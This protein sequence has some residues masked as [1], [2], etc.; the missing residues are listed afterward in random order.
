M[1]VAYKDIMIGVADIKN[2]KTAQSSHNSGNAVAY[3]CFNGQRY[4]NMGN[5][6]PGGS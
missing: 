3:Y 5:E 4:P 1:L 2:Q 6:G